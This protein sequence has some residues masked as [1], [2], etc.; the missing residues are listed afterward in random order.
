MKP[1]AFFSILSDP[2][3][4]RTLMLIQ[5][6]GEVCVCELTFTLNE[7]QPKISR[8]LALMREAGIVESRREGTWMHY[9]I[10]P[11]L[12]NW[13]QEVVQHVFDQLTGLSPYI[14]DKKQLA[15]MNNRP[16][17]DCA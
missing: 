13:A 10:N 4:L 6:E 7:S 8:H 5:A 12:P 3:R 16:E 15:Q 14:D 2:T 11:L 1:E 9:R 17:R